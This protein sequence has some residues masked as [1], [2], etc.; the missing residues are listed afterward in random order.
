MKE[1]L[2][3]L[4]DVEKFEPFEVVSNIRI[5]CHSLDTTRSRLNELKQHGCRPTSLIIVCKSQTEYK[6]FLNI[7]IE[8]RMVREQSKVS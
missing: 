4:L 8:N 6:K 7:W 1:I 2:D 5:L 3:Y